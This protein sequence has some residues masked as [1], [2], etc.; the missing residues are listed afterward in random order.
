MNNYEPVVKMNYPWEYK[1]MEGNEGAFCKCGRVLQIKKP[2]IKTWHK[3]KCPLCGFV[4]N[5]FCGSEG[6][7]LRSQDIRIWN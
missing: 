6:E 4:I 2:K 3:I 5:L 1:L 7:K